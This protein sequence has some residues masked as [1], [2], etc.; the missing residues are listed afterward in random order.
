MIYH[1]LQNEHKKLENQIRSTKNK[2]K[3]LPPGKLVCLKN[4]AYYKWYQRTEQKRIYIPK[5]KRQLAEKLAEKLYFDQ[6]LLHLQSQKKFLD[7]YLKECSPDFQYFSPT[8]EHQSLLLPFLESQKNTYHEWAHT[9]FASNPRSPELLTHQTS[10]GIMVRSKSEALIAMYLTSNNIPFRY[11][12]LLELGPVDLYPDFTI[13]HPKTGKIFYWEHFGQIDNEQYRQ[14]VLSK[15]QLYFQHG[16]LPSNQ[17]ILTFESSRH[18]LNSAL[19]ASYIDL[20]F[21]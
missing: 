5:G 19:V 2:L 3:K 7:Q 16:I 13:R 17:L 21:L 1:L 9:P 8:P 6:Q 11:E 4:G 14:N 15:L 12:C 10:S 18:P 20:F